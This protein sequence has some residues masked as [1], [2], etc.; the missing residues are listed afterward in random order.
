MSLVAN[1]P[2]R[3]RVCSPAGVATVSVKYSTPALDS[4]ASSCFTLSLFA[5]APSG[6]TKLSALRIASARLASASLVGVSAGPA[7]A[8]VAA[9]GAPFGASVFALSPARPDSGFTSG[10][11]GTPELGV[12]VGAGTDGL[13]ADCSDFGAGGATGDFSPPGSCLGISTVRFVTTGLGSRSMIHGGMIT[14]ART[15][16][17]AP[18]SRRRAR[19][20]RSS[21]SSLSR[22]LA[23]RCR[24]ARGHHLRHGIERTE[25]E[26][27]ITIACVSLRRSKRFARRSELSDLAAG[28]ALSDGAGN[29]L[30]R[31]P[32]RVVE[33]RCVPAVDVP[34]QTTA[35][36]DHVLVAQHPEDRERPAIGA[37]R[38]QTLG[39]HSRGFRVMRDV[40]YDGWPSRQ[41]LESSGEL[42]RREAGAKVL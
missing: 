21:A 11:R 22:I 17:I 33:R 10:G 3:T 41:D 8:T 19:L 26:N 31:R 40:Q 24:R 5:N 34:A 14:S 35:N 13:T 37:H 20:R 39:E 6:T 29:L 25:R 27:S 30:R 4:L 12:A 2:A 38:C 32:T 1:G 23:P 16:A 36:A 42:D 9:F 7:R 15:S 28:V 18:M